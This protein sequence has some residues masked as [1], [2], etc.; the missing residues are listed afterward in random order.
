VACLA[1]SLLRDA[2]VSSRL[3]AGLDHARVEAEVAD[4][5]CRCWEA[6]DVADGA[7]QGVSQVC[8]SHS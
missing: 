8:G 1:R 5:V 7:D 3:V 6:P 4:Q 2:A